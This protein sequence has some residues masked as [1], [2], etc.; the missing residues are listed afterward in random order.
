[1]TPESAW[2]REAAVMRAG[3]DPLLYLER[4]AYLEALARSVAGLE[5]ARV[6]LCTARQRTRGET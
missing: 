6:V 3:Q 4:R 2:E 1:M 5:K